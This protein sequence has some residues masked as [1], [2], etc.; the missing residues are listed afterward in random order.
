MEARLRAA[1]RARARRLRD[2]GADGEGQR[3][4][5]L[6]AGARMKL[7]VIGGGSTYTPEVIDGLVRLRAQLPVDDLFL[8]DTNEQ[9]LET[10]AGLARRML[11]R[12]GHPARVVTTP[13]LDEAT[14]RSEE[15]RGGKECRARGSPDTSN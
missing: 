11:A 1:L 10:V 13:D 8:H 3:P 5:L 15:R 9:R 14:E 12:A 7:A 2:T 6:G 4:V